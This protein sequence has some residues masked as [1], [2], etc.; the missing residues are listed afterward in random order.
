MLCEGLI[1]MKRLLLTVGLVMAVVVNAWCAGKDFSTKPVLNKGQKWRI[2]YFE[3]GPYANYPP[4]LK[5]FVECL[6]DLGWVNRVKIPDAGNDNNAVAMW[7]WICANAKSDYIEFVPDACWSSEFNKEKR[8]QVRKAVLDRLSQKKDI[9]LILAMGTWAGQDLANTN[10]SVPTIVMSCSNPLESKIIKSAEDSGLD[11]VHARIDPTRYQRQLKIF[12]DIIGFKKLGLV[13]EDSVDGRTYAALGD[14]E[15]VAKERG[16]EL[17]L[18][19]S[20]F[21]GVSPQDAEAGVLRC[22]QELASKVDAFYVTNHR[23]I[24]DENLGRLIQPFFEKQVPTFSQL[25]SPQVK[26]GV[27]LS[28]ARFGFKYVGRFHAETVARI[29]NGAKP[30]ELSQVFE[31]PPRIAINLETAKRI[32]FDPPI[33]IV[34]SADEIYQVIEK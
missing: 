19:Q 9:D 8:P 20:A 25:G 22:H 16:F 30:R 12:H 14:A 34:S 33:D 17:V 6:A 10:H 24:T 4:N 29:F 28:I 32:G 26:R 7:A 31:D 2:A 11:H 13:F 1:S 27:M 23:G 18:C 15:A 3:A 21:S 5:A